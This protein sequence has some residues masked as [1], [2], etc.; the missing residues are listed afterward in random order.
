MNI[1]FCEISKKYFNEWV[2]AGV[3]L[4]PHHTKKEISKEFN[5]QLLLD[6]YKT[7]IGLN[8]K[9]DLIAFINLSLRSDYVEGS[10][11]SPVGYIEGVYVK[12][13]YR[14]QGVARSFIKIAGHWAKEY[15]CK[16]LASDTGLSN[17][18]S[19]KFHKN[20]GFKRVD[21]IVHFIK[22]IK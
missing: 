16:E 3:A 19:Q 13:E 12:P 5:K 6:K 18:D 15:G 10:T 4:W 21:T 17:I 14:K 2:V 22:K 20:A 9:G 11:T 1:K 7:F 8:E